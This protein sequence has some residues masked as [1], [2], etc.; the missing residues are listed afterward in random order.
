MHG[1][2]LLEALSWG[3]FFQDRICWRPVF[4]RVPARFWHVIFVRILALGI[5]RGFLPIAAIAA[6]AAIAGLYE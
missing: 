3:P 4:S 2:M 6:I 5:L 1:P